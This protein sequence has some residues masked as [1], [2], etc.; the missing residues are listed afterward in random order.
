LLLVVGD[1]ERGSLVD[2]SGEGTILFI[3]VGPAVNGFGFGPVRMFFHENSLGYFA[4]PTG[5]NN[6]SRL[7]STG[8]VSNSTVSTSPVRPTYFIIPTPWTQV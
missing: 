8:E 6:P 5:S 7:S 1:L 4:Q 3:K 2:G